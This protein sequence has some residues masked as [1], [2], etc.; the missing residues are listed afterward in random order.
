MINRVT[1]LIG[2][3]GSGKTWYINNVLKS[4][5]YDLIIDDPKDS[6]EIDRGIAE[7]L[8]MLISDPWLCDLDIRRRAVAKFRDNHWGVDA[9]FFENDQSKCKKNIRRRNDG[10]LVNNLHAFNYDVPPGVQTI[11]IWNPPD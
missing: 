5:G 9:I 6:K 3:P 8:R 4:K 10:R 1:F 2:L 7:G 11:P